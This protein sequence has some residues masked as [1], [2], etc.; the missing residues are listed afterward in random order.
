MISSDPLWYK[1][2]VFYEIH[3][4]AYADGSGDGIGDFQG[5]IGKL[6]Y[7]KWLGVDC[8][9]LLPFYP[10]PLRDD[11][12]DVADFLTVAEQY[13]TMQDVKR[14]LDEAHS[15]G[16]R[17]IV[18]LVLNHTSDR[19]TW[20]QEARSAPTSPKRA[21]YV[22]SDTDRKYDKARII[23]IDTEK[24]NWTWDPE[25]KAFYW[26]RFFSHQP[27]L[28]YDNPEVR[29]AMLDTMTFWLDQGLDGF[30]CDAVPYLF[31]RE[32]TICENLPETHDY[33]KDIRRR[34]DASYQGRILLAEANQWPTD[35]R[36][37]FGDGDEF[38]MAF[39]FPLMPRLYMGVRSETRDPIIDMFTHTP[40]IPENCQWC[41]FLRN[42]DELT[43]EMCSGEERDYMYYTYARDPSMRRNI[44]IGRRL[45][46][47]LDNDRRKIELLNSLV[48]T[49][50]GSPIIYYGD[51]I[52]MGDNVKLKDRDGVRTPMQWTM[53]R[54]AGFSSCDPAQLYLPVVA[55]PVYGYQA[56]NVESQK[57]SPHSL[58][59]WMRRMIAVRK[60]FVAF[61]RGTITFLRPANGKVLAYLRRHEATV[62][63]L[64]HNLAESAQAVELDLKEFTGRIPIELFGESRFAE[65]T[66]RPYVLTLTPY[67]YFWLHLV[68]ARA[69]DE[70]FGI[71]QTAL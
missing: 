16:M 39:N 9:W 55:D 23:F 53:D 65:V 68:E 3:V 41:L 64:V 27:D 59:Q 2:A 32:G 20:F 30:R 11:G 28:N 24:S 10:S 13:G 63:L 57:D 61:G 40:E 31:E 62:L 60:R 45:T 17:V 48:F 38:H 51:E 21:F 35:V 6:D 43:L 67:G 56:V 12:Y 52:G 19:H 42:H 44:G 18:D 70:L 8:L 1:D 50:P 71:E 29:E 22:W 5:L 34:I 58:L 14:L 69:K 66:D 46:P 26:H 25:A 7:L 54:N 15:R 37:Y 33:L 49:L 36:P 4:K 47:L